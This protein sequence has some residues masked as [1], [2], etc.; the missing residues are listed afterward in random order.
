MMS[1][2]SGTGTEV[3][4][5]W[6][7]GE[8]PAYAGG[9][10]QPKIDLPAEAP[11]VTRTRSTKA[12]P[13]LALRRPTFGTPAGSLCPAKRPAWF[14]WATPLPP[15][16]AEAPEEHRARHARQLVFADSQ[17]LPR[18]FLRW[19]QNTSAPANVKAQR[20]QSQPAYTSD[21]LRGASLQGRRFDLRPVPVLA[22]KAR[23]P[24]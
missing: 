17:L 24:S 9:T 20:P 15:A 4:D 7:K 3:G 6:Q 2:W 18:I 21:Q 13:Q 23:R 22:P 1:L 8:V 11:A 14:L 5:H 16:R 10:S 12:V 19:P